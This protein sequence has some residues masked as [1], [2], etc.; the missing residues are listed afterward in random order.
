MLLLKAM[1]EDFEEEVKEEG[2][3]LDWGSGELP[4][5]PYWLFKWMGEERRRESVV[6]M[7]GRV[8]KVVVEEEGRRLG[9]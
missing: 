1:Y 4:V 5:L 2:S 3:A 6:E 9:L 8:M 7:L